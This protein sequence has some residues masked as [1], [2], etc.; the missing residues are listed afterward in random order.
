MDINPK[1]PQLLTADDEMDGLRVLLESILISGRRNGS[2]L[3]IPGSLLSI[4]FHRDRW[5]N[6]CEFREEYLRLGGD[7]VRKGWERATRVYTNPTDRPTKPS[8]LKRLVAYPDK[9]R[10][11]ISTLVG[12]NQIEKISIELAKKPGFSNLSFVILRPADLHDQFRPGYVPCAIAGDFKFREGRLD[13]NVK[14]RTSDA[15]TIAYADIFYMRNLQIQVM[16]LAKDMTTSIKLRNANIGLLNM[17]LC[18]TYIQRT[19]KS[20]SGLRMN[21]IEIADQLV[22]FIKAKQTYN[23]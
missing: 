14:F 9:P 21:G 20:K 3:E 16:K 22:K 5:D 8:Y 6:F 2:Y 12:L 13:L 11:S 18:R 23:G 10:R 17:Y 1:F 7:F 19:L 4:D 15:L